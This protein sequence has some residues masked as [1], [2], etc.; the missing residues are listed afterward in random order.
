[1]S[2]R[3]TGAGRKDF[4][5]CSVTAMRVN[6]SCNIKQTEASILNILTKRI[7]IFNFRLT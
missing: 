7:I 6:I 3:V 4:G 1:M 2:E 5:S